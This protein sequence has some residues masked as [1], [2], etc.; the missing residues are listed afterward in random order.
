[1]GSIVGSKCPVCGGSAEVTSEGD[2]NYRFVECDTCG[3]F[4][5]NTY[6]L[7]DLNKLAS[8]LYYNGKL[9]QPIM[10]K[11][12]DF[13]NFIGP[14][15]KFEKEY[16]THPYCFHVTDEVVENWY[17][18][19]FSEKMDLFLL[20][21]SEI[22]KYFGDSISLNDDEFD[23]AAFVIRYDQ[24]GIALP[25]GAKIAQREWFIDYLLE[26]KYT[27]FIKN[28][29]FS[30]LSDGYKRID[31]LQ[32][33]ATE[34]SKTVFIAMSFAKEMKDVREAIIQAISDVKAGY[35]HRIMDEFEH[36]HQIVPEMLHEIR[37]SKFV[38]AELT[39]GNRGAYFEAGYALGQ[40]KE[41]I[42]LCRKDSFGV[43]GHF[44][45]KQVN[46]ILW[47][48]PSDLTEKLVK[49]I[50]ATIK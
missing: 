23:S 34:N 12:A 29:Y 15:N 30:I 31:E 43:D 27:A 40:G 44:D 33:N 32:K 3:R 50:K 46:T 37:Q 17:P 6:G 26:Q 16:E 28:A 42:Q 47:E 45:V 13:F 24:D 39:D 10:T 7:S 38:I 18:K 21:M 48:E 8:Y 14:K 25:E 1:M 4:D 35:Q 49:R 19:T 22:S 20:G 2:I 11:P 41:V 9:S 36:N 5:Y